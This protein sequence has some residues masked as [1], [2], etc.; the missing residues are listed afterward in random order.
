[1]QFIMLLLHSLI[2]L[3]LDKQQSQF[4]IVANEQIMRMYTTNAVREMYWTVKSSPCI[5]TW[6]Q[7]M[8][9]TV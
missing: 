9:A 4:S 1:M 3:D 7:T 6:I 2:I 8:I 5:F